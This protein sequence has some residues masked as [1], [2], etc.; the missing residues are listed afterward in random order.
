MPGGVNWEGDVDNEIIFG[1]MWL[2]ELD[3][4]QGDDI[5]Y[6]FE[7]DDTIEGGAGNDR[8]FGDA[9]DDTIFLGDAVTILQAPQL[10]DSGT[11]GETIPYMGG[12]SADLG[13]NTAD[14]A[15]GGSGND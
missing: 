3:G 11:Y 1:T 6:G 4:D 2:D 14:F 10:T 12:P 8:V 13:T 15:S 9:G 7:G 5:L